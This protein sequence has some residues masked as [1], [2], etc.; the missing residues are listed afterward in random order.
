[1]MAL[2]P[3]KIAVLLLYRRIF[4]VDRQGFKLIS[5]I[6]I[7]LIAVWTI[8]FFFSNIFTYAPISDM[9]TKPPGEAHPTFKHATIMYNAQC[10][11]DMALDVIIITL[12]LPQGMS[13]RS[14]KELKADP[15]SLETPYEHAIKIASQRHIS[16][17][18]DV[19]SARPGQEY[20]RYASG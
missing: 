20:P 1:M 9:W 7:I 3:T 19:S 12:P 13:P 18:T 11:A 14:S 2:G 17:G 6:L 5:Q 8:G 4:G 16:V 15:L 10:F